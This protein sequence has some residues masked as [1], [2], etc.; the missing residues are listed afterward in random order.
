MNIER[1]IV[2]N[3]IIIAAA[4]GVTYAIGTVVKNVWG[5]DV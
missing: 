4:V 1:R 5:I 2:T 3:L